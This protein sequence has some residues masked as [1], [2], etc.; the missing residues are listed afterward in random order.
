MLKDIVQ[1]QEHHV[2]WKEFQPKFMMTSELYNHAEN[3]EDIIEDACKGMV[4]QKVSIVEW[5]HIFG[6]VHDEDG[7]ISLEKEIA[8]FTRVQKKIQLIWPYFQMKIV[9]V[10]LKV[11][12]KEHIQ[13]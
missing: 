8:I 5:K 4:E 2:I 12:G 11:V 13:S 10:G 3:F 9:V 1:T 6:M 7:I